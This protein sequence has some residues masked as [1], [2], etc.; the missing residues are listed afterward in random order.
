MAGDKHESFWQTGQFGDYFRQTKLLTGKDI[1]GNFTED[2]TNAVFL[3]K[4]VAEVEEIKLNDEDIERGYQRIAGE[5]NMTVPE[6]KGYFKRREEILPF[7]NELLNEKILQFLRDEA[8]LIE[9]AAD[10]EEKA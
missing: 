6:V 10:V 4:K 2:C 9:V 8:K 7:L 3:L 1:T 5:Y